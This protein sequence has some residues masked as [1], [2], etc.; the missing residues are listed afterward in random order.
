MYGVC[1]SDA[2]ESPII[3]IRHLIKSIPWNVAESTR[4]IFD[5]LNKLVLT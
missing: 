4:K 2:G 1:Q 3:Y 5:D